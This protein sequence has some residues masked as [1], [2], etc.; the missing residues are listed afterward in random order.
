MAKVSSLGS[1]VLRVEYVDSSDYDAG[2]QG[3]RS[4]LR[5]TKSGFFIAAK[6]DLCTEIYLLRRP[7]HP[8]VKLR[9]DLLS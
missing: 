8:L 5:V 6:D 9:P 1:E 4:I 7:K 2:V 3:I